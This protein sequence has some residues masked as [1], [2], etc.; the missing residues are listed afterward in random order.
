MWA[1]YPRR[2][3]F[4]PKGDDHEGTQRWHPVYEQVERLSRGGVAPVDVLPQHQHSGRIARNCMI[5]NKKLIS[6]AV[7]CRGLRFA[8]G[9]ATAHITAHIKRAGTAV[10]TRRP[11]LAHVTEIAMTKAPTSLS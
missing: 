5:P 4:R 3:E 2:R 8:K 7:I 11:A 10:R 6:R 9:G 1:A